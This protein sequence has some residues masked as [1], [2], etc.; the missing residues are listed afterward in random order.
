M[1]NNIYQ[2]VAEAQGILSLLD[3]K[4]E[5]LKLME[6]RMS[7]VMQCPGRDGIFYKPEFVDRYC[8]GGLVWDEHLRKYIG[9]LEAA[10]KR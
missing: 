8:S 2:E 4:N 3:N 9:E 1:E 5:L 10:V 6:V 7:F